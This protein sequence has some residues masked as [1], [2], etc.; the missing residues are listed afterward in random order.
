[1][2]RKGRTRGGARGKQHTQPAWGEEQSPAGE[3]LS[4]RGA[5]TVVRDQASLHHSLTVLRASSAQRSPKT[6]WSH[7]DTVTWAS[8]A[9]DRARQDN[10]GPRNLWSAFRG[11]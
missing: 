9:A 5:T 7:D 10:T 6:R 4:R 3:V 11:K 2:Q 1:A 8:S